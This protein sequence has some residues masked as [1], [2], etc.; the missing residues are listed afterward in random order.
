MYENLVISFEFYWPLRSCE[1]EVVTYAPASYVI[2]EA[3]PL[4][5]C[6]SWFTYSINQAI[7]HTVCTLLLYHPY[8]LFTAIADQ[9]SRVITSAATQIFLHPWLYVY[10]TVCSGVLRLHLFLLCSIPCAR[11]GGWETNSS[12]G[13]AQDYGYERLSFLVRISFAQKFNIKHLQH[14]GRTLW[15]RVLTMLNIAA[16][17]LVS[18]LI[19]CCRLSWSLLYLFIITIV[20]AIAVAFAALTAFFSVNSNMFI[21]FLILTLYGCT[22]INLAFVLSTFLN[23]PNVGTSSSF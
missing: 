11:P 8:L 2:R 13:N 7:F 10:Q 21:F 23:N 19:L 17:G 5:A 9:N 15:W 16:Y 22:I 4:S 18:Y 1:S 14:S 3:I 20:S 6:V 12:K